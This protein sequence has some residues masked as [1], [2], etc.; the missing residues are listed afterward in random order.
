MNKTSP[1]RQLEIPAGT[2][3]GPHRSIGISPGRQPAPRRRRVWTLLTRAKVPI[4]D[5]CSSKGPGIASLPGNHFLY[6]SFFAVLRSDFF[7]DFT[8]YAVSLRG[9]GNGL[10]LLR[11]PGATNTSS[12]RA[13]RKGK[14]KKGHRSQDAGNVAF[15]HPEYV[16]TS[17]LY[18]VKLGNAITRCKK[19]CVDLA[20]MIVNRD[21]CRLLFRR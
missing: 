4:L 9:C 19:Q 17:L 16:A 2:P 10:Q 11:A 1:N 21:R 8:P 15:G 20:N 7:F 12:S 14:G 3:H 6:L 18:T 5:F 13:E